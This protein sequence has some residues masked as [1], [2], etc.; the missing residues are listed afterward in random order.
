MHPT[1]AP[2][3]IDGNSRGA[4]NWRSGAQGSYCLAPRFDLVTIV[5]SGAKGARSG[6]G[7]KRPA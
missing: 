2:H 4:P 1:S 5:A 3:L 7:G 6:R